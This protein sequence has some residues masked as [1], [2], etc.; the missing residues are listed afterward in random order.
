MISLTLRPYRVKVFLVCL[1][2]LL[3]N[4]SIFNYENVQTNAVAYNSL[5]L[6]TF[7]HCFIVALSFAKTACRY[8]FQHCLQVKR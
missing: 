6:R 2:R 7:S 5:L 3:Q 1:Q 8:V 4:L